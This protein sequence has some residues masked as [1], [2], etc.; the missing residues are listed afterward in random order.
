MT[1]KYL[2]FDLEYANSKGGINK[3]CEFGYVI[4]NENFDVI[5]HI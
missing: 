2:F 1:L 3:I 5:I 4:T